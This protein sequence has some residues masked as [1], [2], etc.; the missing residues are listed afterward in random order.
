MA[1]RMR[2]YAYPNN[3]NSYKAF[4]A[5]KYVG[6]SDDIEM[7]PAFEMGVTN[8]SPAFLMLNPHGKARVMTHQT[9]CSCGSS[10]LF[11]AN[12]QCRRRCMFADCRY[13]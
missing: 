3:K 10:H 6:C 4:I 5:A 13:C 9:L 8:K 2:I 1:P 12:T 11:S 7:A